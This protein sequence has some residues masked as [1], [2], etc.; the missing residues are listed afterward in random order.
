MPI[1]CCR[2]GSHTSS[3]S[4][5]HLMLQALKS[6]CWECGLAIH[7]REQDTA[8][9]MA[10]GSRHGCMG[11]AGHPSVCGPISSACPLPLLLIDL[12]CPPG[13]RVLR[14]PHA[15]SRHHVMM[16][17]MDLCRCCLH[18]LLNM[19]W[20]HQLWQST[21]HCLHPLQWL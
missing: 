9:S 8:C 21:C 11:Q 10:E 13:I 2:T 19:H 3:L 15:A 20:C 4:S 17:A 1:H 5:A 16:C 18:L 7:Q 14:E 6:M 12:P